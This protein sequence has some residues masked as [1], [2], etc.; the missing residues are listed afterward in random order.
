[1]NKKDREKALFKDIVL[2]IS[3]ESHCLSRHVAAIA[4]KNGR[5]IATGINGTPAHTE[6]CDEFF[7]KEFIKGIDRARHI[8]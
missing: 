8:T 5:I 3:Q 2:R 1:M 7:K 4:V 6:N